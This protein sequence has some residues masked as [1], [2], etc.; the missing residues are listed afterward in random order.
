MDRTD[1]SIKTF[2]EAITHSNI[3]R[4]LILGI[5]YTLIEMIGLVLSTLGAFES[6]IRLYVSIVVLFHMIYI[7]IL[8][9]SYMKKDK[10]SL[11]TLMLLEKIYFPVIIIWGSLFTVLV[12]L[13]AGD[14]TIY[15]IIVLLCGGL[16]VVNPN[17]SRVFYAT[18]LGIFSALIYLN[19]SNIQLAN[20]LVF[21][22]VIVTG[23]AY[24]VSQANYRNRNELHLKNS[25]L[26]N[27]NETLK[28]Q[29]LRDSLTGLFNNGYV[30]EY[31]DNTID[32]A[33]QY[34]KEFSIIMIDI[35]D[36]KLINDQ[37]GHLEGDFVIKEVA[38]IIE[39]ET[40]DFDVAARYGGEEFIV[41]LNN[42]DIK[43]ARLVSKRIVETVSRTSYNFKERV[44]VSI[45]IAQWDKDSRNELIQKAD[46]KL[47]QAK[48]SG[49]NR[50][51]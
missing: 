51:I 3:K 43:R 34:G 46:D 15:T 47:Y 48:T 1:Y 38:R 29:V 8:F 5:G 22:S 49:K 16:F 27:M 21:K 20:G 41:V 13:E 37:Y 10:L 4:I 39:S 42:S 24:M 44:T 33:T 32:M 11:N 35:D 9:Y 2:Q 36:F 6:D 19:A 50:V 25:Q 26:E 28:D 14:I 30:F 18:G 31:I 7:P 45:G 23:I 17:Y 40:R 12:Y